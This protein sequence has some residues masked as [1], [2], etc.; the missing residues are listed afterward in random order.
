MGIDLRWKCT[1]MLSRSVAGQ[2]FPNQ[3]RCVMSFTS[4]PRNESGPRMYKHGVVAIC[5]A[6][7]IVTSASSVAVAQ[8]EK[9]NERLLRTNDGWQI[10][11]S[12]YESKKKKDAAVIVLLH[13]KGGNRLVWQNGFAQRMN[14][15][16]YAVITVDLRHHGRSKSPDALLN[17]AGVV[18]QKKKKGAQNGKLK[19]ADYVAMY[20]KDLEAVKKFIYDEHQK[21]MLNMRKLAIVAAEMTAP[22]AL[23]FT[24]MDWS[25]KPHPD[26]P[27]PAASTPRGQDVQA[28][29]LISPDSN[30][31]GVNPRSALLFIKPLPISF[32]VCVGEKDSLDKKQAKRIFDQMGGSIAK[33][34]NADRG[35]FYQAY[36]VK[37]RGTQL[38]GKNLRTEDHILGFLD[39]YLNKLEVEWRDRRSKLER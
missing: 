36:P 4:L 2:P 26:G 39:K 23:N 22:I 27:N 31:P 3:V 12:Y 20:R 24:W 18:G 14:G 8:K 35:K 1:L 15:L 25:K 17:A 34:G 30:C 32:L 7:L 16:G 33:K 21:G 11:I 9:D 38:L 6:G 10:P 28:L 29:V 37:L 19:R 13:M 5:L